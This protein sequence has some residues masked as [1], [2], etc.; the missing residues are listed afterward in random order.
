[1]TDAARTQLEAKAAADVCRDVE[2]DADVA[3]LLEPDMHAAAMLE[4]LLELETKRDALR[5]LAHAIEPREAVWLAFE[6]ARAELPE[7]AAEPV[8][9]ALAATEAWLD[10]PDDPRRR[11]AFEAANT[12]GYESPQ[13]CAALSVFLCEGSVGPDH[14]E[15]PV[16]PP[17][18][19]C[20][21]AVTGSLMMA[22]ILD[23]KQLNDR[24]ASYVAK[25]FELAEQ[26]R[27]WDSTPADD[28]VDESGYDTELKL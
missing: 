5:F 15:Q 9:A 24:V 14:L 19:A 12:S 22:A 26:P 10:E 23:P 20:A 27:P 2:F 21:D 25:W 3:S 18:G 28:G 6:V 4:K 7:D 11:A 13:G 16:H 17:E 8:R 1:M